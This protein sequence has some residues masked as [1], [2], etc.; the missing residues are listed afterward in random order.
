LFLQDKKP[1]AQASKTFL[2]LSKRKLIRD[3]SGAI[4]LASCTPVAREYVEERC[5]EDDEGQLALPVRDE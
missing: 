4:F 2:M 3:N 1:R 5:V